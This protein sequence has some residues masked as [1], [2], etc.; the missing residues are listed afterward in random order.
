MNNVIHN[1]SIITYKD[2]CIFLIKSFLLFYKN[3]N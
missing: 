2:I 3:L 1:N